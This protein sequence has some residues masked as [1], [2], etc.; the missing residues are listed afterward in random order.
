MTRHAAN[1]IKVADGQIKHL[2]QRSTELDQE[3]RISV[4]VFSSYGKYK[5]VVWDK[6][7]LRLPSIQKFYQPDGNTAFIDATLDAIRDLSET[8]ERYGDHSFLMYVLTDGEEN[9]SK[10]APWDLEKTIRELPDHWT[11][12]ALVPNASGKHEAKKFGFP[13]GNIEIWDTN[14]ADGV[15][16]VGERIRAATDT[17]MTNRAAGIRSTKT[18]F[19]TDATA[20]NANTVAAA[21]L[22]PL[23]PSKYA[24]VPVPNLKQVPDSAKTPDGQNIVIKPFTE[25]CGFTYKIGSGFYQLSKPEKIQPQKAIMIMERKGKQRVFHGQEARQL[26]GLPDHEIRVKPDLNPDYLIF[27]Q[28]GS[29]NRHLMPGT[30]Y[31]YLLK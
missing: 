10:R 24:V 2:A 11:V 20:V 31:L 4:M 7:V 28:S 12:A 26:V 19:S 8:P 5:C 1:L 9:N 18:L 21:N 13:N 16:E 3:T 23:D 14:S 30:Q 27:V 6:D 22:A 29:I 17:Y 25:A 15:T